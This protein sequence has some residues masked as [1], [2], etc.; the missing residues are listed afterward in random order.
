MKNNVNELKNTLDKDVTQE[1]LEDISKYIYD[2]LDTISDTML[3]DKIITPKDLPH[4]YKAQFLSRD[5]TKYLI[6]IYPDFEIW[7]A[8]GKEKGDKFISDLAEV[9]HSITGTPIFMMDLYNAVGDELLITGIGLIIILLGVL[10]IHFKS[11]KYTL[12]AFL[13]LAFTLVYMVGTMSLLGIKFNMLN[14]LVVLLV[15]GIGLDDGVHVLHHYKE[16]EHNIKI[17]FS[18]IGRAI[19][20]TTITTVFGF[21][22]LS[23]SSYRGIA[24]LGVVLAIGVSLA[25]IF[26]IVVLPIFLK[27]EKDEIKED[28][29]V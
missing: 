3:T 18:T 28:I 15:I 14:F 26:T 21:G 12:L 24:G 22:S 2:S 23:F 8:L 17:L 5:E 1:D 19:L 6:T 11:I 27:D 7:D 13:P 9:N 29:N 25:L 16:G 20:L 4:A 10:L